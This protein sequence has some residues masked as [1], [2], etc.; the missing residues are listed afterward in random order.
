MKY[1][2]LVLIIALACAGCATN[3]NTGAITHASVRA[4]VSLSER[5]ALSRHPEAKPYVQ[6]G[7]EV[8]CAVAN[9]TNANPAA[10]VAALDAAGVT[11][12]TTR[13]IVNGGLAIVNVAIAAIGTNQNEIRLYSQDVCQGMQDGM[14]MRGKFRAE[15]LPPHLK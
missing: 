10:I 7:A 13:D 11:N 5:F 3:S 15:N 9:S 4:A 8:I 6:A 12:S 1:L 2:T 14:S